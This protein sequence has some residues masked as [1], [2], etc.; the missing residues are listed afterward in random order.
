VKIST[1]PRINPLV[2]KE[3]PVNRSGKTALMRN[4]LD[5]QLKEILISSA[6]V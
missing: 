5:F 6:C 4:L 1:T 2:L 3:K